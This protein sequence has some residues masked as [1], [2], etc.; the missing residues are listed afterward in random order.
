MNF[1]EIRENQ[2]NG[3]LIIFQLDP[4]THGLCGEN[5]ATDGKTRFSWHCVKRLKIAFAKMVKISDEN[6]KEWFF[7]GDHAQIN[8]TTM[9][10]AIISRKDNYWNK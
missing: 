3:A 10:Y 5:G 6:V 4:S 1:C 2:L 9:D 7:I 8:K